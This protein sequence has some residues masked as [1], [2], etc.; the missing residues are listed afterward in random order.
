[1]KKTVPDLTAYIQSITDEFPDYSNKALSYLIEEINSVQQLYFERFHC[2][3]VVCQIAHTAS[4]QAEIEGEQGMARPVFSD[5]MAV[6]LD[7][8]PLTLLDEVSYKSTQSPSATMKDGRIFYKAEEGAYS[9][10][11]VI[12]RQRPADILYEDGAIRGELYI[13]LKH[14]PL[15]GNKIRECT[16]RTVFEYKDA[17]YYAKAYNSWLSVLDGYEN[18]GSGSYRRSRH[19]L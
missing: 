18:G 8:L 4:F 11:T 2:E 15:L 17:D 14:L 16:A 12:Y 9:Q 3:S 19:G 7:D 1:M 10:L 13:P 6:F 5:L